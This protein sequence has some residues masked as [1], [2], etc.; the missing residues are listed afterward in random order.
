[1]AWIGLSDLLD[2]GSD[3]WNAF[4]KQR[5][6]EPRVEFGPAFPVFESSQLARQL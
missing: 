3:Y 1:L 6:I 5:R 4:P 2:D